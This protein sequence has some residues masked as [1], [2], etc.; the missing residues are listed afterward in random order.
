D[1]FPNPSCLIFG[2]TLDNKILHVVAGCDNINLYII[3]AYYPT[4]DKFESDLKTRR[5]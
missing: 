1:D 4:T 5:K 3:T 2:I